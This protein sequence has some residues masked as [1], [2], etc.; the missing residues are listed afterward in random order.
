MADRF[1]QTAGLE[2]IEA[3]GRDPRR[4][5]AVLLDLQG[6]YGYLSR[7][8]IEF[9]SREL[10]VPLSRSLHA[11]TFYSALGLEPR[12][13]TVVKVCKGTACHVRGAEVISDQLSDLLGVEM[14]GTTRDLSVTLEEVA[15][16][17]ACAMAPVVLAGETYLSEVT[18]SKVKKLV[19]SLE[20]PQR[21]QPEIGSVLDRPSWT[22]PLLRSPAE[23]EAR[24]AEAR[25]SRGR[26]TTRALVCA[27]PGC[28]AAGSLDLYARLEAAAR[29]A[30]LAVAVQL[31][32]CKGTHDHWNHLS[33][34]GCQGFCQV[35]PLVH[36]LPADVLYVGVRPK[37]IDELVERSLVNGEVIERLLYLDH[38]SRT[39]PDPAGE[40][41]QAVR[42]R[43][44]REIPFYRGQ[45]KVA[46]SGCGALNPEDL[47]EYL[48]RGGFEALGRALDTDPEAIVDTIERSGLRGRGG[49][50]FPTGRKWRACTQ[51]QSQPRSLVCNGDEGDPGAFMD[52][53]IMEGDPFRIIEGMLIGARAVG[54]GRGYVYVRDEYPLAVKR[55]SRAVTTCRAA[56]LLGHAILGSGLDF[57][58]EVVRGGGAFVCG[59][60][61][62]LLHSLEGWAGEPRQRPPYPVE[63]G[64]G[65]GPTI[66]NNVET[67]ATIAPIMTRGA[68]WFSRLGTPGSPGTKVFS[69]VGKVRSTGLVEVPM[70]T[71]LRQLVEEVGGGVPEGRTLKAV[72]TG[73]PSGGCI[74]ADLTDI[75]V[76]FDALRTVGSMMGSGG[77]I[78]MDDRTC[79]VDVARYFTEFLARESCGK[80]LPCRDGLA[81]LR[82]LLR[83]ICEGKGSASDLDLLED[84]GRVVADCSLCGL[85]QTA[86][87]PVMSTLRYFRQEYEAHVEG[88]C[89]AGV[90]RALVTYRITDACTGCRVCAKLCP[91]EAISGE[92]KA[93]HRIDTNACTRC[94]ICLAACPDGAVVAE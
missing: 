17:G 16:V 2:V 79:M 74:P 62:A 3:H 59:E 33:L 15:C 6:R 23:L 13:R 68:D 60:E 31:A 69:L 18:P 90:C 45:E 56:G 67:W 20:E 75:A 14:G 73:G 37:D 94:G 91:V 19:K 52:R 40:G 66:I 58:V 42:C 27:G 32:E 4:L 5:L 85:G 87:N 82:S 72:Q 88:R 8:V 89:P 9:A 28:V 51:S 7:E 84:L 43:S 86:A 78:V 55:M 25:A 76:D 71:T 77:L 63:E 53:A 61:T 81:H 46:L 92:K 12:G 83:K 34:S 11:A 80:C 48:A 93:L 57:D 30:G 36:L 49:A 24:R 38:T 50:G 44:P 39:S 21:E 26:V 47:D 1:D 10:G 54:A 35:G 64:L 41:A 29:Q 65:G 22:V 70:G